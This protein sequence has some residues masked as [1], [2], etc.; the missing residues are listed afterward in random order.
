M[1]VVICPTQSIAGTV[2]DVLVVNIYYTGVVVVAYFFIGCNPSPPC[3]R[4]LPD[5]L[6]H[7]FAV[8]ILLAVTRA[9]ACSGVIGC[10]IIQCDAVEAVT[11]YHV[12][13]FAGSRKFVFVHKVTFFPSFG[14]VAQAPTIVAVRHPFPVF[15]MGVERTV[16]H[17]IAGIVVV[18]IA[19]QAAQLACLVIG[20][21]I[22]DIKDRVRQIIA[23]AVVVRRP[24][25]VLHRLFLQHACGVIRIG[26]LVRCGGLLHACLESLDFRGKGERIAVRVPAL[27]DCSGLRLHT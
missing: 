14:F 5:T 7:Q 22:R 25:E 15:P 27:A 1:I 23:S 8:L 24:E 12:V 26:A 20:I 16:I 9:G 2:A 17:S 3:R 13:G 19:A 10:V 21:G 6:H 18:L 4:S 11:F